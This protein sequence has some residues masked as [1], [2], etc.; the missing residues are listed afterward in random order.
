M[1]SKLIKVGIIGLANIAKRSVIPEFQR[2]KNHFRIEAIASRDFE[3]AKSYASEINC[4]AYSSYDD[5][6]ENS[7]IDALYIPLP[8]SLHYEFI[9]K[10]LSKNIHILV[11]KSLACS[12]EEVFELNQ[13][14]KS[15]GLVLMETF[16]FRFHRQ[17]TFIKNILEQNQIGELRSISSAFCFPPFKELNN[18]RYNKELGGG[19]LLDAGAYTIKI[20]TLVVGFG[21]EVKAATLN[22]NEY[23]NVD[24]W[25]G[26][27]LYSPS[28]NVLAHLTFG[29]DNFYQCNI[30]I[31]GSKGKVSTNRIFTA[32][33][34]LNPKILLEIFGED[35]KEIELES[36]NHFSNLLQYFHKTIENSLM[37]ENEYLENEEQARLINEIKRLTN[38]K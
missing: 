25:G 5:L 15:K 2:L 6:I 22:S 17:F 11:E 23:H 29:F 36:D 27:T 32:P 1:K 20:A 9:K 16:Q 38:G 14:A 34:N 7:G 8:N 28:T 18:I 10:A 30:E 35:P 24:I 3:K 12:Y 33:N 13:L 31:L 19:A 4:I 37:R 21:L 26:A